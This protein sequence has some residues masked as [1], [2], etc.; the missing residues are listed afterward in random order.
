MQKYLVYGVKKVGLKFVNFYS[1]ILNKEKITSKCSL[2]L[3]DSKNIYFSMHIF[4]IIPLF[5][6]K[7]HWK[8]NK[9]FMAKNFQFRGL[10][11]F[12]KTIQTENKHSNNIQSCFMPIVYWDYKH[13]IV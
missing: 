7:N 13:S 1:F 9:F 3:D 8:V 10:H 5:S 6:N 11:E 12:L 2:K 4:N